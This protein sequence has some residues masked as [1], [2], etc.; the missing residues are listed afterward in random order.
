LS[1]AA[2][3]ITPAYNAAPHIEATIASVQEQHFQDWEMIIADDGSTDDTVELAARAA[4]QDSRIRVVASSANSGLP[5]VT[6]NRA[7]AEATA[8]V[9][10]FLDAD[11]LWLP[12]KLTKQLALLEG[13]PLAWGF[14]NSR[15]FGEA[16]AHPE[17]AKYPASWSPPAPF[18]PA[19]MAGE[20][21]PCLTIIVARELLAKV[22]PDG[23]IARAFDTDPAFRAVEDW[24][25]TL[26]LARI[27]EPLYCPEVLA[28][29][30][31]HAGGI[32]K[33]GDANLA[34][35]L[36]L[37]EKYRALGVDEH[38]LKQ[39]ENLQRSKHAIDMLFESRPWRGELTRAC[40][41]PPIS[42]RDL[43]LA[44][45]APWPAPLARNMYRA[46][47]SAKRGASTHLV[48]NR[49]PLRRNLMIIESLD[50]FAPK[51]H[52]PRALFLHR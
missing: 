10:A 42:L 22:S 11:D 45:L 35:R 29:Y 43:Y 50:V 39:A 17:G 20:G 3:I 24:D 16:E 19:L 15:F 13:K 40:L 32:S 14:S 28:R 2:S 31:V 51:R 12:E 8:P 46:G 18:F 30:R 52:E 5:S 7:L 41:A 37:I 48:R 49:E 6:R 9:I 34:A 1:P 23:D 27:A 33:R 44:H 47:L 4:R 25:L 26:R 21:V 36:K 38:L